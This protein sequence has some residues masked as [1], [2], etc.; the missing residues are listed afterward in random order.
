MV[1]Q[2]RQRHGWWAVAFSVGMTL[3]S[4]FR[5]WSSRGPW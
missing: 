3:F 5:P 2:S 1:K 4:G